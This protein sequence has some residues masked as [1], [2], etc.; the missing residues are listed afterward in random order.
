MAMRFVIGRAGTGKT[1]HC[2]EAVRDAVRDNPIDGERLILLVPEQASLQME[3]AILE[4]ADITGTHRAEVLSFQ[5]LAHKVLESSGGTNRAALS[6]P[7]RAMVLRHLLVQQH[8]QLLYYRRA[9]RLGGFVNL[10]SATVAELIQEAVEPDELALAPQSDYVEPAQPA[11]LHD[12]RV[13]YRAYLD[14]L[15][16][17]RLD[18]SQYLQVARARIDRCG[19]LLGAR[20]WVDGFASF[21]GQELLTL[22]AL[23][24]VCQSIDI[25]ML[26]D[27]ALISPGLAAASGGSEAELFGRVQR[28]F[29]DLTRS[30]REAGVVLD[31]PVTLKPEVPPRFHNS[32]ALVRLERLLFAPAHDDSVEGSPEA[33]SVELVELPALRLEVDYAVSRI[34][35]WVQESTPPYRYRD[36]AVIVRDLDAYHDL[37]GEALN[38][39]GIPFFID[40]RRAIAHHPLVELLRAGIMLAATDLSLES[41][42]LALKTD[43]LPISID[44]ADELENYLIAHG[45]AGADAWQ[46]EGGWAFATRASFAAEGEEPTEY[47]LIQLKRVNE[48]RQTFLKLVET[49]RSFAGSPAGHTGADWAAAVREW[50]SRV[51]VDPRLE[52][53]A[54]QAEADGDVDQAAEHL[55]VQRDMQ[56]FLDDLASAFPDVT[57]TVNE[58]AGVVESG[59]SVLTL[60]LAPPMI[61]QVL[62]GSI[63]RSRHPDIKAAVLLGFNDG[64]FPKKP[65]EESILNDDDRGLLREG[66]VRVGPPTRERVLD[67]RLLVYI[68]LTRPSEVCLVTYATA[69][70]GG[71]ALRPSPYVEHLRDAL[72]TLAARVVSDPSR[73]R[74]MWDILSSRD[75][76]RR[77]AKEFRTRPRRDQDDP[78]V[79]GRWNELYDRARSDMGEGSATR[80]ALT[81]LDELDRASLSR[82]SIEGLFAGPLRT[83]ISQLETYAACPFQYF[84]KYLLRLQERAEAALAP[85]DVGRLHHAVLEEFVS[86]VAARKGGF[87]GLSDQECLA[88]LEESW[89]KIAGRVKEGGAISSARDAYV[90]RR[91]VAGLARVIQA[92]K[93]AAQAGVARAK[94]A[95]LSFGFGK[96]GGLPALE[97][98]T[99]AG[100]RVFLRGYIDRVDLA[101]IGDELLGIV[102]DYKRTRDKQLRLDAV[103]H[104]LSL[105]LVGYLLA[106]AKGGVTLAGRP[107]RPGGALFVSLAPRYQ[108][109]DHPSVEGSRDEELGGTYRP[110]GLLAEDGVCALDQS[111]RAGW[112]EHYAVFRKKDGSFGHLDR[113]D[114]ADPESFSAVLEHTRRKI[115]ELADGILDGCIAINPYRLGS[116]SP[117]SWCALASVCRFEMGISDVRFL[118]TLKRADVFRELAQESP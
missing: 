65:V 11:K 59:L 112:S 13:I 114:A 24:R 99:P 37:L 101:E 54:E 98:S 80:R 10:L 97:L 76:L 46:A 22:L 92:Q 83:S 34:C 107:I 73:T 69:D 14:Y 26:M 106:L 91:S 25:T 47:E 55:Q 32:A 27:P 52:Q 88:G 3:R 95:E 72:P 45:I 105:Q 8:D 21:S 29:L 60:G 33:S 64:V 104:G 18:P 6:E 15:G 12:L 7:A 48:T 30:L 90:L 70:S 84:A 79:R 53:W 68:A 89:K 96:P 110:R 16:T 103:Y 2:L 66:G 61:D 40:R 93:K 81:G 118:E 49:W 62:V 85:V 19:W 36:I 75:L 51:G 116:S 87:A 17:Q 23:A 82:S 117:C 115:G 63:E 58:L 100:R 42:R 31:E 44:A 5:R 9:D 41:V 71:Q 50:F 1:H 78:D 67:E 113:S 74:D 56:S 43:L 57:L 111:N 28:T 94:A 108:S 77:L 35:Q 4:P 102:I 20:M 86:T 109:V 38:A 39:R